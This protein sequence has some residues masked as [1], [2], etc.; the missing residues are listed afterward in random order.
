MNIPGQVVLGVLTS[1]AGIVV[2]GYYA[3][4]GCDPLS[5]R[6]IKN[7][8]QVSFCMYYITPNA[9]SL[10]RKLN[11]TSHKNGLSLMY[12]CIHTNVKF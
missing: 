10:Q 7:P 12:W 5:Q 9:C 8:N 11:T 6:V 1:M 3:K 4:K 2:F